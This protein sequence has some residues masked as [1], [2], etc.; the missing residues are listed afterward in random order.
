MDSPKSEKIMTR[1]STPVSELD[2]HRRQATSSS[3]IAI[4][5]RPTN[6]RLVAT[7]A[8]YCLSPT[9]LPSPNGSLDPA[10]PVA[11]DFE[12]AII[13]DDKSGNDVFP[14]VIDG[15]EG[16]LSKRGFSRRARQAMGEL[17]RSRD[18]ST[19]DDSSSPPN[20]IDAFAEPRR[21]ERANTFGSKVQ[22]ELELQLQRT[23][24]GGTHRR[25]PTFGSHR[26][27]PTQVNEDV[28][29][30]EDDKC[31][32][33]NEPHQNPWID[34]E[35]LEEFVVESQRGRPNRPNR[36]KYSF[37]S[38]GLKPGESPQG[39]AGVPHI[40]THSASPTRKPEDSEK[41]SI[42]DDEP[43]G[44]GSEKTLF[45][46][47]P[48]VAESNRF[49][50]F[51]SQIEQTIHAPELGDL[52]MPEESF[53]DLFELPSE[54]GSWW[55][56][57]TNPTIDELEALQKAFG[58]H[59]L[60]K[61][62][63]LE[64][65][66]REKV[67]LFNSYYF[68]N[69]KSFENDKD[70]EDYLEGINVYMIVF[71]EGALTFSYS[72]TPHAAQV[73]KKIGKLRNYQSLTADWICYAMVDSIVDF[74]FPVMRGIEIETDQIE[75][76]VFVARAED[77][78]TLLKQIG[79][80]RKRVM[81]LMRLLGGKADVI[82]GFA[83]RCNA[84]YSVTPR[85][86]IGLYLS[87]IQDH[88]VTMMSNLGHFEKMLSRSHSNYLAQL[89]VDNLVQGNRA[90]EVLSKITVIATVIVPMN[91]VCGLFG[92]N[93]PVPGGLNEGSLAW[94]G[95]IVGFLGFIVIFSLVAARYFHYI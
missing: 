25:R 61:E 10:G 29:S 95:G 91:L 27:F 18:S 15:L 9:A 65:E 41:A 88:I 84:Q 85:G 34:Y 37:S 69:F 59:P 68:V 76:Q 16:S 74:F 47:R 83:K 52:V 50:F 45:D 51:S 66:S 94:F 64:K 43:E 87:D 31:F 20:S 73:R 23:V 17:G 42:H 30:N 39:R 89:S 4:H 7:Q 13:D 14:G 63:I 78:A 67:E 35:A 26:E 54:S 32:D 81:S 8:D 33:D 1:F 11:R 72:S 44:P 57:V 46:R 19:S 71:R 80:C 75:D 93:V 3:P 60:T 77:F 12:N 92:M 38:Q 24:S 56:D 49:S 58:I 86:D 70:H 53:R 36:K 5:N 79:E 48:S 22:S 40:V 21:R 28:T 90:N 2:D 55:L 82:K 6:E 62:D